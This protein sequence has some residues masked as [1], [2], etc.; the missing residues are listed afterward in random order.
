M[1]RLLIAAAIAF[2]FMGTQVQAAELEAWEVELQEYEA[3]LPNMSKF[4]LT[5]RMGMYSSKMLAACSADVVVVAGSFIADTLPVFNFISEGAA[6]LVDED[7]KSIDFDSIISL[8]AAGQ[9]G[10]GVAGG[11]VAALW[12]SF[13]F[14]FLWLAGEQGRSYEAV[15]KMYSSSFAT[16]KALFA[17]KG[18]CL[19]SFSKL[20]MT[21]AELDKR[22]T[23]EEMNMLFNEI[24]AP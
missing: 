3:S 17:E 16:T 13:E 10:R 20:L 2:G 7:Y 22:Q 9:A 23:P 8:A 19:M 24:L 11:G 18:A 4:S 21:G 1:T 6:N 14:I 12:E 15:K 5:W